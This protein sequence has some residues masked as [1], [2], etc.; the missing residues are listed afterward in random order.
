MEWWRCK[1][2]APF[3]PKWRA[4]ATRCDARPGDVWAVFTTL[5]DRASQAS[6]R[7]SLAG[8]DLDDLAAGLGYPLDEVERIIAAL[9]AK[10]LVTQE[11]LTTWEKHQPKREDQTS[12]ERSRA[13]REAKKQEACND[14]QRNA[15]HGD[16]REEQRRVD[17]KEEINPAPK[18][19][20]ALPD[21]EQ[22][23]KAYP[24][25]RNMSKSDALKA[26]KVLAKAGELPEMPQL[27]QAVSA[28]K[29]FLSSKPDH[30]VKHAQ[31]WLN[32]KRWQ[33]YLEDA[34]QCNAMQ[35]A[36]DWAD[37]LP[38]WDR[39]KPTVPPTVWAN[40]FATCKPNGSPST[41][42]APSSFVRDQIE[43]RYGKTLDA[44]FGGEFQV[45]YGP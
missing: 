3:D 19:A 43:S 35:H 20:G 17:K 13:H 27:L 30:P 2:G 8:L 40:F 32:G 11:R 31:G 12:T 36:A 42:I 28:Y 45:K 10:G 22:F 5:C 23:W 39:F 4:V 37:G 25:T 29:A 1:H 16:A 14:V 9:K 15:T 33:P 34:T 6:E 26:W 18:G 38:V 24:K 41:L 44:L 21:F 7:G